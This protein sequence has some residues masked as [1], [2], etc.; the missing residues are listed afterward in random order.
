MQHVVNSTNPPE[1][2]YYDVS[3]VTDFQTVKN[4]RSSLVTQMAAGILFLLAQVTMYLFIN[5]SSQN[6]GIDLMNLIQH[7]IAPQGVKS[8]GEV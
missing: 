1:V 4:R 7:D 3:M 5:Q 6:F 2:F 8:V